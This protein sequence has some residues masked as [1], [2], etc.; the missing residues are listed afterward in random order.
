[1]ATARAV[2]LDV[3]PASAATA[4]APVV[5]PVAPP[6]LVARRIGLQRARDGVREGGEQPLV[7]R[8]LGLRHDGLVGHEGACADLCKAAALAWCG[9]RM[10]HE[11][12]RLSMGGAAADRRS[13]GAAN[14][15]LD[16]RAPR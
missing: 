10:G 13:V 9:V 7:R 8:Q 15:W 4:L 11:A 1:M 3:L 2:S 16:R 12:S 6:V 14:D 5:V